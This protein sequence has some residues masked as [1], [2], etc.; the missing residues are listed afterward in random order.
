M[1]MNKRRSLI[2]LLIVM[3]LSSLLSFYFLPRWVFITSL[4]GFFTQVVLVFAD[5][6]ALVKLKEPIISGLISGVLLLLV[7]K[8]FPLKSLL[9]FIGVL[10]LIVFVILVFYSKV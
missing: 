7:I 6:K 4:V 9:D 5:L 3:G 8:F 2:F 1:D 10:A